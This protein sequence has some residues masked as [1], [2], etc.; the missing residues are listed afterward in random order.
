[1]FLE[2][3]RNHSSDENEEEKGK[4]LLFEP[5]KINKEEVSRNS[6]SSSPKKKHKKKKSSKHSKPKGKECVFNV[7]NEG[8]PAVPF[9]LRDDIKK[10]YKVTIVFDF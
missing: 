3:K 4:C 7:M 6:E 1:M 5:I 8:C 2:V 9:S 10:Y